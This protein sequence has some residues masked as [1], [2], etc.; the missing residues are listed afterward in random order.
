MRALKRRS[1]RDSKG[2]KDAQE[3]AA[4]AAAAKPRAAAK[5]PAISTA[6]KKKPTAKMVQS[7]LVLD[8]APPRKRST[9]KPPAAAESEHGSK[10]K[11]T[12]SR[13]RSP[14]VKPSAAAEAAPTK[15]P[16]QRA[17]RTTGART[18]AAVMIPESDVAKPVRKPR[19]P[20]K[21][22]TP[23]KPT[24]AQ[25]R[26]EMMR[27]QQDRVESR[28]QTMQRPL[29][30]APISSPPSQAIGTNVAPAPV[31]NFYSAH[32]HAQPVVHYEPPAVY[33]LAPSPPVHVAYAPSTSEPYH[34][35]EII[36]QPL[37]PR[38]N[39]GHVTD[40][41]AFDKQYSPLRESIPAPNAPTGN[42]SVP[43]PEVTSNEFIDDDFDED[44]AFLQ[45]LEEVENKLATPS[46]YAPP[47]NTIT[48]KPDAM[49]V[50]PKHSDEQWQSHV[51]QPVQPQ[52]HFE[53]S[54][55]PPTNQ[56][57]SRGPVEING[58]H[59]NQYVDQQGGHK[60]NN[61]EVR[62]SKLFSRLLD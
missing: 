10:P 21:S 52:L 41:A 49:G 40:P 25:V 31:A 61:A 23:T 58:H 11:T 15:A 13:T 39:V 32:E 14:A 8:A 20:R 57:L 55:S 51:V 27:E 42:V 22:T 1:T 62:C 26:A 5:R 18:K 56:H 43:E 29:Q 50:Q 47:V 16:A 36:A 60:S 28:I 12:A 37:P 2:S 33:V 19:A 53:P 7:K 34:A 30:A 6:T 38:N 48:E 59:P 4:P 17:P 3:E 44:M 45:A 24:L 54:R 9:A 46:K 35:Q